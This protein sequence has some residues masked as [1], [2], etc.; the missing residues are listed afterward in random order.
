[1]K[2]LAFI[3][4]ALSGSLTGIGVL[5]KVMHWPYSGIILVLGLG[6][7]SLV[8]LPSVTKYLYDKG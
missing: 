7:F 2:K 3:T 6:L 5:F 8:F 1:M 4:G